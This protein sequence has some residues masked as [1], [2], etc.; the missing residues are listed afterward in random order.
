MQDAAQRRRTAAALRR[1]TACI[2]VND[3]N[4]HTH[5]QTTPTIDITSSDPVD[6]INFADPNIIDISFSD[7][8][9]PIDYADSTDPS[10]PLPDDNPFLDP[11]DPIDYADPNNQPTNDAYDTTNNISHSPPLPPKAVTPARQLDICIFAT[12][13]THGLRRIPRDSEGKPLPNESHDY[14]RYE[15]L[16]AMMK[17]KSLDVYF[18]Q[19]TWLEGDV[20]DKVVNGYHVFR[21]NGGKGNHNF[22]GVAIILSPRYHKGWKAA[23]GRPPLTTD[24]TS[25]FAGR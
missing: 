19:E 6:P 20:F 5:K 11:T 8:T 4:T 18:V 23:G 12:Q 25:E 14:T 15:H 22:R 2:P 1:C 7:L 3:T 24:A 13:N 17:T 16:I 10:T 21:H 9:D